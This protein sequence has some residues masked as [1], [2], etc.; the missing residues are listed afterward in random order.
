LNPFGQAVFGNS[1]GFFRNS[2]LAEIFLGEDIDRNLAPP[3]W[4]LDIFQAENSPTVR[5]DNFRGPGLERNISP[6]ILT[7]F[8]ETTLDLHTI[9]LVSNLASILAYIKGNRWHGHPGDHHARETESFPSE[10]N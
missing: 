7:L 6:W 10:P 1:F 2:R 9:P 3:L 5:V 4:Y 8:G